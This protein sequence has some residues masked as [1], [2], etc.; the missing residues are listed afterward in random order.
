[1]PYNSEM[2]NEQRAARARRAL[3]AYVV[4]E[5]GRREDGRT[6]LVI[7][8]SGQDL[9]NDLFHLIHQVCGKEEIEGILRR[10][11]AGFE[12]EV[13]LEEQANWVG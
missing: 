9:I 6:H 12:E 11:E 7:E 2:T 10:A 3:E 13:E 5:D 1:M 4:S 8:E